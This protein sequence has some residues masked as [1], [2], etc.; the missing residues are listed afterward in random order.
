MRQSG[1]DKRSV[2]CDHEYWFTC[3]CGKPICNKCGKHYDATPKGKKPA[4]AEMTETTRVSDCG[5]HFAI[6]FKD[7]TC[8]I[9]RKYAKSAKDKPLD[10]AEWMMNQLCEAICEMA[11]T[12]K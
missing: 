10:T 5:D 7:G 8:S 4:G 6:F 2:G 3:K 11:V 12:C 9:L 1:N